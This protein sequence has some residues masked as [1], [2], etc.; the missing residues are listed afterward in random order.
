MSNPI[1]PSSASMPFNADAT[2]APSGTVTGG[3]STD[4]FAKM[5]S[6]QIQNQDPLDP[7]DS[8][9]F[10]SQIMQAQQ[11]ASL[12]TVVNLVE[13]SMGLIG[14]LITVALGTHVGSQVMAQADSVDVSDRVVN[15]RIALDRDASDVTV[16]LTGAS[17]GVKHIALGARPKGDAPFRID[18]TQ[19]GLAAGRYRIRVETGDGTPPPANIEGTLENVRLGADGKVILRVAGVGDVDTA[20]I[21]SFQGR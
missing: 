20:A 14:K 10:V 9:Q 21:V 11:T 16:V 1:Q 12:N 18:P 4:I 13:N 17:G 8:A 5:L 7:M 2:R 19:L 3:T 15:G 6:A